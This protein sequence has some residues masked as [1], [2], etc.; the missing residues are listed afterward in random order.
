MGQDRGHQRDDLLTRA[1]NN[2]DRAWR[3]GGKQRFRRAVCCHTYSLIGQ[4]FFR[5]AIGTVRCGWPG[6][7]ALRLPLFCG[8]FQFDI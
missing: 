7:A 5:P 4:A 6:D 8:V 1:D 2:I 3:T